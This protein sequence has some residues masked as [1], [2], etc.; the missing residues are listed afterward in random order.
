MKKNLL[1]FGLLAFAISVNSQ[2]LTHIDESGLFYVGEGALVYNGGGLQTKSTG[3]LEVH[4]NVMIDG[5]SG[6]FLKTLTSTNTNKTNGGNIVLKLNNPANYDD[7]NTPSSPSQYTF[8][9]LFISGLSQDDITGVVNNEYRQVKHG[10]YQQISIPF[11]NKQFSSLGSS[12]EFN[13]T[14]TNNRW[15]EDEILK[16]NNSNVVF[17]NVAVNSNTSTPGTNYYVLGSNN[18]DTSSQ[19]YSIKGRPYAEENVP[20]VTLTNAGAGTNF[21]TGGNN[22]NAYN[23]KYN[24]YLQDAFH[25]ASGGTAWQGGYGK[26][27]YQF[28]NPFLTNIDLSKISY[29]EGATITDQI[30]L[31]NIYGIRLEVSG[32][33]YT[34]NV[35]GAPTSYKFVTFAS[36][37]LGDGTPS[38]P[39]GDVDYL[40]V[41]PMGTF[42]IKLKDNSAANQTLNFKNLRRFNYLPRAANTNYSVT[43]QKNPNYSGSVK[44]LGV[45]GLDSNGNEVGRTYYVVTPN[46]TTGHSNTTTSQLINSSG[47]LLGTYEE[48]LSGGYDYNYTNSYW[49][50]INEANETNFLGKNIKLVKYTPNIVSYKFEIRENAQLVSDNTHLLSSGIGFYYKDA[51]GVVKEAKQGE[52]VAVNSNE[53]DLYYGAPQSTLN[54]EE[55]KGTVPSRTMVVY[56]PQ[57]NNYVVIFD[58]NWNKADIQVYD[59]SGKLIIS[60]RNINTNSNFTIK[61]EKDIRN[62]Y[63]VDI[64][65]DNGEKVTTKILK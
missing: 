29:N 22:T 6:D 53:Y 28:G 15:S 24:T 9:Q 63:I 18:L 39:V 46:A 50:Y 11:F 51:S 1:T 10:D 26:N 21:G 56:D 20:D 25:I 65:S 36:G 41:R 40:V 14:F 16:W 52:I 33:Q 34:P 57:V 60:E 2:V 45:I 7:V 13:K 31:S 3:L 5:A 61:L 23:E 17:D 47:N 35:G 12:S 49:L 30:N 44:Q 62:G 59:M 64:K 8:G 58:P 55:I 27:I 43:A 32:V 37:K 4:G 19:V 38:S 54:S 42:V 48:A